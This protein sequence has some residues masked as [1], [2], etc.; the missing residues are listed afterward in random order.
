MRPE[1]LDPV[2]FSHGRLLWR[3]PGSD[4]VRFSPKLAWTLL[5]HADPPSDGAILWDPFCGIGL[6]PAMCRLFGPAP[7][8]EVWASDVDPHA[9]RCAARNLDLVSDLSVAATRLA[10]VQ[11]LRRQNEKSD[12]RWAKVEGYIQCLKPSIA[13]PIVDRHRT[14]SGPAHEVPDTQTPICIVADAPYGRQSAWLGPAPGKVLT[15]WD[16]HPAIHHV[17]LAIDGQ[18]QQ[19]T[20]PRLRWSTRPL[21]GGRTLVLAQ[22]RTR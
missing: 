16:A 13:N 2:L 21:R 22:A 1:A 8:T 4:G 14:W 20:D 18:I 17:Q 12:R 7:F 15:A 9:V 3:H 11:G 10:Q 5:S 19:P 6:I